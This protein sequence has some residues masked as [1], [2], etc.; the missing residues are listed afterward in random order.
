MTPNDPIAKAANVDMD[1]HLNPE[2]IKTIVRRQKD[3]LQFGAARSLLTKVANL[4][5]PSDPY[6]IWYHQQLALC[7]YKDEELLPARR[8]D[9]ALQI[10]EEIGLRSPDT[11]DAE[12]LALGGAVY[13]RLWEYNGQLEHLHQAL[14][15]YQ[16]AFERNPDQDQGYGGINAAYVLTILAARMRVAARQSGMPSRQ[17]QA[18][19]AQADDLRKNVVDQLTAVID[20]NPAKVDDPWPVVTLAEAYYGLKNYSEAGRWL[21]RSKKLLDSEWK[22][23]TT[24][25]QLVSIARL[26]GIELPVEGTGP[27]TWHPAW[28]ILTQLLDDD[29][30]A[31]LACHRGKV[32]LALSGGGFRASLYHLGVLA[33]LAEMDVLRSVE[34]LSTVSGGSIVGAHYYLEVKRLLEKKRDGQITRRDYIE[35]V[36]RVQK[37]FLDGAQTNIRTRALAD[38][39]KNLSM[40]FSKGYSRSHRLGELYEEQLFAK[41]EDEHDKTLPRPMHGLLIHPKEASENFHPKFN[42]WRR[43]AKVPALLLN[44]TALN[45]GHSWHFT[46]RS[47]GEPP[48]LLGSAVDKN[49]R[50]RRMWYDQAPTAELQNYRL[51]YAVAASACVPGLFEPL[52]LDGLY[53]GKVVQLVD[54]GVHD[55]QGVAGLLDEGCTFILCSDASGQMQDLDAPSNGLPAVLMRANTVMMDR[56]REAEYQDL[57]ARSDSRAIQGLFFVHL[58]KD[59]PVIPQDW[60]ACQDPTPASEKSPRPLPYGID[61]GVQQLIAGIRTDLDAFSEVEAYA[62]MCS[63]YLM[64]EQQFKALQAQHERNGEAGTWGSYRWDA[65]REQWPFLALEAILKNPDEA[66]E[67]GRDLRR[68]LAAGEALLFKIWQLD[69]RLKMATWAAGAAAVVLLALFLIDSWNRSL[70]SVELTAGAL[71]IAVVVG[72]AL[73]RFP[74]LQ[75]LFPQKATRGLFRK[76]LMALFGYLA[77]RIHLGV[78]NAMFLERGSLRRL[79]NLKGR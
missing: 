13:K 56:V 10:L 72:L 31:A 11:K 25:R 48:G 79:L 49:T 2:E 59:L 43:R 75:W 33:R 36:G 44:A 70:F 23:Q 15:F 7:T 5:N 12:T 42:N 71:T 67:A 17:A 14:F 55:N 38:F 28:Q 65:P 47:M 46:A 77:A 19:E 64:A 60:I 63:G 40:I 24:F 66:G 27:S 78:F 58:K 74:A 53:P 22:L 1:E 18:L 50:Y 68:Q 41:V 54:G 20:K 16:A 45:T 61:A 51:G 35:I 4:C 26:N 52:Q 9:D 76:G 57:R 8:F 62:L 3:R 73:I 32:G 39:G 34:T 6:L 30:G 29:T 21:A 37:A 69:P